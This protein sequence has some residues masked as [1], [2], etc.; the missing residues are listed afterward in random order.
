MG[1]I[2]WRET[3]VRNYHYFLR[4]NPEECSSLQSTFPFSPPNFSFSPSR[5]QNSW[6]LYRTYKADRLKFF[7]NLIKKGKVFSLQARCGPQGLGMY[8]ECK[9]IEFPKEYYIWICEQQDW[10]V[11]QEIDGKIRWE[12]VAQWLRCCATNRKV[13]DSIPAGVSE[14]FIDI[15]S[16]WSLYGTGVDSASNRNE[17]QQYFVGVKT[18][19][20]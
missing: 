3:S 5:L 10:E 2:G 18:V 19:G 12:V 17:Y 14:F 6:F 4:N 20:A 11:D 16:F 9:K 1:P 7:I 15:K 8:R 13:V